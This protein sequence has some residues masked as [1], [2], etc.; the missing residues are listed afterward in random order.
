MILTN[1]TTNK[2]T[3]S[4][5]MVALVKL[6]SNPKTDHEIMNSKRV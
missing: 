1:G 6:P 5:L 2:T 4:K 3:F